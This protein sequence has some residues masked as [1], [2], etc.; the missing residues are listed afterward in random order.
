MGHYRRWFN[1]VEF[2]ANHLIVKLWNRGKRNIRG[3]QLARQ[4]RW[5]LYK[6]KSTKRNKEK[7]VFRSESIALRR[8]FLSFFIIYFPT[9]VFFVDVLVRMILLN[10]EAPTDILVLAIASHTVIISTSAAASSVQKWIRRVYWA[11][12]CISS[13]TRSNE[14]C[15]N[16]L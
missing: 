3:N 11:W 10:L 6:N 15:K 2:P 8:S 5:R 16:F 4:W 1:Q 12:K 7:R 9:N 14:Q 13:C